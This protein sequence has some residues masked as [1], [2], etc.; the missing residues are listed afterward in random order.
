M[1]EPA[2]PDN[3]RRDLE[4]LFASMDAISAEAAK[5][6]LTDEILEAEIAAYN[7]ERREPSAP[8]SS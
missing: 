6:G 8:P 7:A 2:T 5:R 1:H 4:D 3:I